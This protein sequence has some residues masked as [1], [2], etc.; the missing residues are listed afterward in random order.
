MPRCVFTSSQMWLV[1]VADFLGPATLGDALAVGHRRQHLR[2]QGTAARA[3]GRS[4]LQVT[5]TFS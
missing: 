4:G 2:L 3:L 5:L 1:D